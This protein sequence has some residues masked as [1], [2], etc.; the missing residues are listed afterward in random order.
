M[1]LVANNEN[2]I[3]TAIGRVTKV[4]IRESRELK[5]D[6]STYDVRISLDD[7]LVSSC[8]TLLNLLSRL[9]PKLESNLPEA[10]VGNMVTSA[11]TNKPTF[12]Q[13]ALG[14]V[15]RVKAIIELLGDFGLAILFAQRKQPHDEMNTFDGNKIKRL[16]MT[17]MSENVLPDG[18]QEQVRIVTDNTSYPC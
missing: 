1:K 11:F 15:I 5:R 9:S 7:A 14:V 10:M 6:Q 12:V 16:K 13:I 2:D 17:E 18:H 8:P 4:I 3:D